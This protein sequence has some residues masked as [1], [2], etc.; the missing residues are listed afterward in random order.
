MISLL[1]PS[2]L[3]RYAVGYWK[4]HN[5]TPEPVAVLDIVEERAVR[6]YSQENVASGK[7]IPGDSRR[8]NVFAR[9][10]GGK[11]VDWIITSP[12]YYGL[13]TYLPDQWLRR[14]FLGGPS[15][16]E[17]SAEGQILHS[18]QEDFASDLPPSGQCGATS[19]RSARR[20][21]GWWSDSVA[22]TIGKPTP[23]PL[24]RS[25]S[26]ALASNFRK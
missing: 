16:V 1:N 13:R 17:Y 7:A 20:E 9:A 23:C 24:S 19:A 22:S 26:K 3:A 18:S 15:E 10:V 4:K 2:T 11:E 12:P 14:W 5:L 8:T 25:P 6:Y 21:R